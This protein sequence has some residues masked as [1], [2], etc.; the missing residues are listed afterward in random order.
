[1]DNIVNFESKLWQEQFNAI[2][3]SFKLEQRKIIFVIALFGLGGYGKEVAVNQFYYLYYL[4]PLVA[5]AF[6]C[7]IFS[8]KHTVRRI[9]G[10][11]SRHSTFSKE[12]KWEAYLSGK[13]EK[14]EKKH[15]DKFF[16]RGQNIFT[17]LTFLASSALVIKNIV[18]KNK[19]I[20]DKIIT[21]DMSEM[22]EFYILLITT[23]VWFL[24]LP[25]IAYYIHTQSETQ[26]AKLDKDEYI[27]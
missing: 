4:V 1:M 26:L 5:I 24:A 22:I 23:L 16:Y 9:G 14:K 15:R 13:K 18:D 20:V 11:L 7:L 6:D 27:K 10:F 17:V 19:N 21:C 2:E 3:R 12:R 25:T 8:Q